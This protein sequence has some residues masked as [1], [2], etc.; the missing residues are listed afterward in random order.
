MSVSQA[1]VAFCREL[2]TY[3]RKIPIPGIKNSWD[4]PKIKN[5]GDNRDFSVFSN[6]DPDPEI[7]SRFSYPDPVPGIS[8]F[9]DL[10]KNK[11]K[12]HPEANSAHK[13]LWAI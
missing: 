11:K 5:P 6:P 13:A 4:I 2:Q 8:E 3:E 10:A 9:C 12:S 1:E 7:F